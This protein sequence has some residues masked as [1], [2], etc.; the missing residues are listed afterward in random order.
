[1]P[2]ASC[3]ST[4]S[5]ANVTDAQ[6]KFKPAPERWSVAEVA[7]HIA[8]SEEALYNLVTK[9]IASMPPDAS[10]KSEVTDEEVLKRV[11]DRTN[12]A[13][14]PEFLRPANKWPTREALAEHFKASRDRTIEYVEKTSDDL[15]SRVVKHPVGMIDGYQWLLLIAAHTQRHVDQINEVK[16]SSGYPK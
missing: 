10:K 8:L 7:E 11:A 2:R 15:R 5:I 16:Q 3:S 6:W 12:R 1:M 9:K 4:P 14:A 13:N